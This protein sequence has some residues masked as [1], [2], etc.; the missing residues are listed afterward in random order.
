MNLIHCNESFWRLDIAVQLVSRW[1]KAAGGGLEVIKASSGLCWALLILVCTLYKYVWRFI[2][3]DQLGITHTFSPLETV[4]MSAGQ[5]PDIHAFSMDYIKVWRIYSDIQ[6]YLSWIYIRI[7]V[8]IDFLIQKYSDICSCQ[9]C[10]CE[11]IRTFVRECENY[12]N[13]RMYSNSH[14]IFMR[15]LFGSSF[16]SNLLYEY[17]PTLIRVKFSRMLHSAL[18][19]PEHL[20]GRSKP[21]FCGWLTRISAKSL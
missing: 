7:F 15:I 14:P 12:S 20:K 13:I 4:L 19:L 5:H 21:W 16:V 1:S 10:S 18:H 17:I 6:R 8:H 3:G 9:I 11:Y 2:P